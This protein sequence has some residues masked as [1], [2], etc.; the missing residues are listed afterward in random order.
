MNNSLINT[1]EKDCRTWEKIH[2]ENKLLNEYMYL[3][4][5][6]NSEKS[7]MYQLILNGCELWFGTLDE[8]NAV[9]KSMI[10]SEEKNNFLYE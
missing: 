2:N 4:K 8:I 9:V 5:C 3:N 6:E 10:I 7:G 1:I